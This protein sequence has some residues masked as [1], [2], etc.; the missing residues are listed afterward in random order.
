MVPELEHQ[1]GQLRDLWR[2]RPLFLMIKL[3]LPEALPREARQRKQ[4]ETSA[5]N[6]QRQ[7]EVIT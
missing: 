1:E 3:A 5:E 2:L 4:Q 6:G 7:N